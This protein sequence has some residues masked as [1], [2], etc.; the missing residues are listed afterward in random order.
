MHNASLM[1]CLLPLHLYS[2]ATFDGFWWKCSGKHFNIWISDLSRPCFPFSFFL[3]TDLSGKPKYQFGN[4]SLGLVL[5]CWY[6]NNNHGFTDNEEWHWTLDSILNSC[7]AFLF[8]FTHCDC[9]L[10]WVHISGRHKFWS[11]TL[12]QERRNKK[13]FDIYILSNSLLFQNYFY[14]PEFF[15]LVMGKIM[16]IIKTPPQPK[17]KSCWKSFT[18]MPKS[19]A[20]FFIQ[21]L[22]N[23]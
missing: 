5:N 11:R 15:P 20:H 23:W 6:F 3:R 13:S 10:G 4:M 8:F 7:N 22:E 1:I 9:G 16:K 19:T 18:S 21:Y 14:R 2:V 12:A 17:F